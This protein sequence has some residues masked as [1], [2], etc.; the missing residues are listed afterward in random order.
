MADENRPNQARGDCFSPYRDFFKR[1]TWLIVAEL[2]FTPGGKSIYTSSSKSPLRNAFLT[3]NCFKGHSRLA[4]IDMR[5]RIVSSLAT[6]AKVLLIIHAVFLRIPLCN[7]SSF[8]PVNAAIGFKFHSEH[9]TTA[10]CFLSF[11]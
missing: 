5:I 3:S 4:A 8:I 10:N 2:H 6:G 11:G 1:Q 7:Q 9:P